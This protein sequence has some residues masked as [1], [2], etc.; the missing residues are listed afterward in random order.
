M[1]VRR[2]ATLAALALLLG[3]SS[4]TAQQMA[5]GSTGGTLGKTD[6][7]LSGGTQQQKAPSIDRAPS[8]AVSISGLWHWS[9]NC[10]AIG[11]QQASFVLRQTGTKIT[12]Q[13]TGS[14]TWGSVENG[15]IVGNQLSFNRIGGPM[16]VSEHWTARV[17]GAQMQGSSTG[18]VSCT[19]SARRQ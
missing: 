9:A 17:D 4:A 16:G 6:Q 5:Q 15:K 14:G 2:N 3:A 8:A 10:S 11:N 12:G 7:S 19:F 18:A 13:F 1:T